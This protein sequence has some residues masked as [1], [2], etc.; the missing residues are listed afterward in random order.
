LGSQ[1]VRIVETTSRRTP[2]AAPDVVVVGAGAGGILA[3]WSAAQCGASVLLLEKTPRIGT[4]ILIS[5]GGKCNI[6]HAGALEDVLRAFTR[7]EAAFL[8]PACYRFPNHRIVEMVEDRALKTAAR[9]DGRVFPV[10]GNAK[11]VIE[12]LTRYLAEAGVAVCLETPVTRVSVDAGCAFGV[13]VGQNRSAPNRVATRIGTAR[14][15]TGALLRE[16]LQAES[17]FGNPWTGPSF[18]PCKRIVLATGGTSYPATGTTGDGWGW[19]RQLG[20]KL[21]PIRP[22]LAPIYL[23]NLP[24]DLSGADLSGVGLRD[25]VLHARQQARDFAKATG[26]LLLTHQGISGP[27]CL[28]ISREVA[29]RLGAGPVAMEVDLVPERNFE[30]LTADLVRLANAQPR[31]RPLAFVEASLPERLRETVL[32]L[33]QVSAPSLAQLDRKSRNRLVSNLKR[34]PLGEVRTVPIDK[35]EVVAGGVNLDEVDPRTMESRLISGLYICGEL[36]DI[37]GPVGGYNL[38]AAFATGFVAGEHSAL[39][40]RR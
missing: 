38:Q 24:R 2:Y 5:G 39:A 3:A 26:D 23:R 8:R 6:A 36:L 12:I 19:L 20:H 28:R 33:A 16:A 21:T 10:E 7:A 29:E 13:E 35:G 18:I 1:N 32:A 30:E 25:V 11:D 4:K 22:A 37:A 40:S 27:A 31:L 15:G 14:F 17:G 9:S 34:W